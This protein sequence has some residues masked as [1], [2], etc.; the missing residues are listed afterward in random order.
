MI[1]ILSQSAFEMSTEEV[2]DWLDAMGAEFVRLNRDDLEE[3]ALAVEIDGPQIMLR[4]EAEGLRLSLLRLRAVRAV[5]Y[6]RWAAEQRFASVRLVADAGEV[7]WPAHAELLRHLGAE[8]RKLGELLFARLA[9][10]PWLTRPDA[11]SPLKPAVLAVAAEV[12]IDVPRTLITTRRAE[13]ASFAAEVGTVITKPLSEAR[14]FQIAG[15]AHALHTR[16][17]SGDDIAQ[18]PERFA[19]SLFQ[20][21]LEKSYELRVFFLAGECHAMAI[22]SQADP[23]TRDDFR[24]YNLERPARMVPYRLRLELAAR[25]SVLMRRLGLETG[26]LDLVRTPGG[27]TVFLEVNPVGQFG[28]VSKPCN[29]HLEEKVAAQLLRK[30]GREAGR[31]WWLSGPEE[32]CAP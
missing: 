14:T 27:R 3:G 5:W 12:G 22:F 6:R 32:E 13:L 21:R 1:L 11:V 4:L 26:S 28:M 2:M 23:R 24:H 31:R 17:L 15:R 20:E 30:A 25:I 29:Y 16:S 7:S 8:S 10:L 9:D 18:L 19:P